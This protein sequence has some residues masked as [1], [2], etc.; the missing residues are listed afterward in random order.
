[1]TPAP[2]WFGKAFGATGE[3]AKRVYVEAVGRNPGE[4][5]GRSH[6]YLLEDGEYTPMCEFGWNR[7]DGERFSI[8]RGWRGHRGLCRT[9]SNRAEKGLEPIREARGH[10]TQWI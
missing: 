10:K 1:M 5:K 3:A 8:F 9:C 7:S 2:N 4:E 6:L